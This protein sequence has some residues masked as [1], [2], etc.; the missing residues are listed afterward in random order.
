MVVSLTS[1]VLLILLSM[2]VRVEGAIAGHQG[3]LSNQGKPMFIATLETDLDGPKE[4]EVLGGGVW[5]S[6]GGEVEC[7]TN[8]ECGGAP[9]LTH[10]T[11][12]ATRQGGLLL[13]EGR[14]S[15]ATYPLAIIVST[16]IVF[17]SIGAYCCYA[18]IKTR[19]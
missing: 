6:L 5:A 16:L 10:C 3:N 8:E 18:W 19:Q 17:T 4:D 7:L 14:C 15:P 13:V 11:T 2:V 9:L 1:L 12:A